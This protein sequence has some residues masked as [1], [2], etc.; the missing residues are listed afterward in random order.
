MTVERDAWEYRRRRFYERMLRDL[1]TGY[2][3]REVEPLVSMIFKFKD[4]FPT[5]SCSGRVVLLAARVPWRKK[6]VNILAK[7]HDPDSIFKLRNLIL[8]S[9]EDNLWIIMQPPIFHVS[10]YSIEAASKILNAARNAGFKHSGIIAATSRGYHVE[11]RGNESFTV[12]ARIS[13]R[14]VLREDMVDLVLNSAREMLIESKRRI[15]RLMG[16]LERLLGEI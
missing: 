14:L 2:F 10:C 1:E 12:P 5:S 8:S 15:E 4:A 11:V 3:D 13:G 7:I 16:E 6:D 9:R